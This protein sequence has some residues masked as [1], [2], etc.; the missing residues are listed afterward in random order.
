[1]NEI[2]LPFDSQEE[3][4]NDSIFLSIPHQKIPY[5]L[6]DDLKK[7]RWK[8]SD[9]TKPIS[10][11]TK[12]YPPME[13]CICSCGHP[14]K[15]EPTLVTS[16]A[17]IHAQVDTISNVCVYMQ[18]THAGKC[19][20]KLYYDGQDDLLFNLNNVHL[21]YYEWLFGMMILSYE[22]AFPLTAALRYSTH[23]NSV[24]SDDTLGLCYHHLRLAYNE[25]H[26]SSKYQYE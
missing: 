17:R 11:R 7:C 23:L 15:D 12:L 25:F 10:L 26:M 16:E 3:N 24:I 9:P 4:H 14:F 13:S 6:P 1:M 19:S 20:C 21:F 22:T 5:P 2:E 18:E 8:F